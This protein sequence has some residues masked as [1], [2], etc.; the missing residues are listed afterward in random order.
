M[1]VAYNTLLLGNAV[2]AMAVSSIE[3]MPWGMYIGRVGD[4][5]GV[6]WDMVYC[7]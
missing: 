6:K 2:E 1:K 5:F 7:K 4:R 3:K